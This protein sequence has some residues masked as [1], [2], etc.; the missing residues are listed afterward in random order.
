MPKLTIL[1]NNRTIEVD[2]NYPLTQLALEDA[3]GWFFDCR[4][5]V[6]GSCLMEV[7]EGADHLSPKTEKE[8]DFLASIDAQKNQRLA[9]LC[10][11]HGDVTLR[12]G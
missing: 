11:V 1:N 9:C 12:F 10:R 4:G 8:Q 7:I 2:A 3:Y 6:C 5:G